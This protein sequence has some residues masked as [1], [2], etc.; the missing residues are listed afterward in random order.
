MNTA[1]HSTDPIPDSL[2]VRVGQECYSDWHVITQEQVNQHAQTSG[3]GEGEWV[4]LDPVRAARELPYGG[5]IVQ[6]F[7]Q[8]AHLIRLS[9]QATR[10]QGGFDQN[11]ALNY[12]FDRL[13]FVQPMPVG[14]RFRAYVNTVSVT[15]R[16]PKGYLLCQRVR[17]E[18]DS[19]QPTLL[20]DWLFF[21]TSKA[22]LG[23]RDD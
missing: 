6:G 5:T 2:A 16:M 7:L 9:T 13:R 18:L 22:L 15:P 23:S 10:Y 1:L 3:D 8:V 19:G 21:V 17:L 14:A 12:G 20:A 11:H 4:H